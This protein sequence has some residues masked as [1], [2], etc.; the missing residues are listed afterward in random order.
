MIYDP[1][2]F[3]GGRVDRRIPNFQVPRPNGFFLE[4]LKKSNFWG[5]ILIIKKLAF[6]INISQYTYDCQ[7]SCFIDV[8]LQWK[9]LRKIGKILMGS[10]GHHLQGALQ[11]T[12]LC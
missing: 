2:G 8:N 7:A 1:L 6:E 4:P 11:I 9:E 12:T 5:D 10:L 3:S